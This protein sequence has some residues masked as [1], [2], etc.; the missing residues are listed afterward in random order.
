MSEPTISLDEVRRVA[1]LARLALPDA[2][3]DALRGDMD[4]I[5]GF[6]AE[7]SAVDVADVPPTFLAVPMPLALRP[8]TVHR[9]LPVHEALAAAP[10]SEAG[11]FA[12]PKVLEGSE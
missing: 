11:G 1:A 8:D 9:S 7:L 10:A 5:L 3:L 6:V 4:K 12:V 2:E